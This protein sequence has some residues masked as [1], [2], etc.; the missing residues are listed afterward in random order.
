MDADELLHTWLDTSTLRH[1]TR[2]EYAREIGSFLTWCTGRT[3]PVDALTA[4]PQ[5]IAA[6][7]ADCFLTPYLGG[8]PFDGPDALAHLADRHP[9]AA[10]THDRRITA[11]TQY[12]QAARDRGIITM[13]PNLTVLR[14]G[15]PRPAGASNR[16]TRM[17]RATLFAVI[18]GWGPNHSKHYQRDRLAIFLLLEGLRPAQVVRV[19]TRHLYPQPDGTWEVRAPDDHENVGRQFTLEPLTGAA[20]KDYLKVRPEPADPGEHAL[21]L[22]DTRH[23]LQSRWVNKLVGQMAATHPLLADRRDPTTGEPLPPATADAIAH[24]GFWDTPENS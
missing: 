24:T 20:L 19:D 12:F 15:V 11:L 5:D 3:P 1:S 16:L 7:A 6:W 2:A 9:E 14:S 23:A 13:P 22:N 8:R 18:G 17:E 4:R 21:L 10:R